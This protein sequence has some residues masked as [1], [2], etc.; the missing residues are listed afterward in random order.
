MNEIVKAFGTSNINISDTLFNNS[1]IKYISLW[2]NSKAA[3]TSLPESSGEIT[4][5][6][7]DTEG[8]KKFKGSNII[9]ILNQM[10]EFCETLNNG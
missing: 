3:L 8:K 6:L 1:N 9:D 7:F 4:F 10:K 2:Y 5:R